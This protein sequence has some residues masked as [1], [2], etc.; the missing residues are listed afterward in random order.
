MRERNEQ[1]LS[2]RARLALRLLDQAATAQARRVMTSASQVTLTVLTADDIPGTA[3]I[4]PVPAREPAD[5][6]AELAAMTG[7]TEVKEQVQ[8]L[9][10]E[11]RAEQLRRD[12]GLTVRAPTRHMVFAGPPGTA[13][14]TVAGSSPPFMP[15]SGCC[16]RGISSRSAAPT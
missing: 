9:A 11:A 13:K 3:A 5:P 10:A 6:L 7:L 16:P 15:G 8:R 12:A 4:I 2:E 1:A 14:T